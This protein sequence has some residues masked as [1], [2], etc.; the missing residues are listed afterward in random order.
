MNQYKVFAI[1]IFSLVCFSL[2]AADNPIA[3]EAERAHKMTY[4]TEVNPRIKTDSAVHKMRVLAS[5][6][7][8]NPIEH[9]PHDGVDLSGNTSLQTASC[10]LVNT[11]PTT[12]RSDF[13]VFDYGLYTLHHF[14][15]SKEGQRVAFNSMV[16]EIKNNA[17]YHFLI[18]KH[19]DPQ[20][21][22]ISI[23]T[24]LSLPTTGEFEILNSTLIE[25]IRIRVEAVMEDAN[26]NIPNPAE[27]ASV[28]KAGIDELKKVIESILNGTFNGELTEEVLGAG[29]FAEIVGVPSN[30]RKQ[31]KNTD[32]STMK[33]YTGLQVE[34]S[35]V[36]SYFRD[37]IAS[38]LTLPVISAFGLSYAFII[39]DDSNYISGEFE[40][41]QEFYNSSSSP[42]DLTLWFH[43]SEDE[44]MFLNIRNDIS[45]SK[46]ESITMAFFSDFLASRNGN[47]VAKM[48]ATCPPTI[49]D[50]L[51]NI[52]TWNAKDF[53]LPCI[54]CSECP[55]NTTA[56]ACYQSVVPDFLLGL[57]A[58]VFDYLI[59]IP[60]LVYLAGQGLFKATDYLNPTNPFFTN[61]WFGSV[62]T[63]SVRKSA[64][65]SGWKFWE[66]ELA[67]NTEE[68]MRRKLKTSQEF[69]ANISIDVPKML[70]GIDI[71]NSITSILDGIK[72]WFGNLTGSNGD[73]L[74]GY[75]V[76]RTIAEIVVAIFTAGT[77]TGSK[78][79]IG[80]AIKAIKDKGLK[81][82]LA[83]R[84]KE[85]DPIG[86]FKCK[87]LGLGCFV[88]GT[89]ILAAT[90]HVP[91]ESIQ[92]GDYVYANTWVNSQQTIMD[93]SGQEHPYD[94]F[95]SADQ[96]AV[97]QTSLYDTQW[98]EIHMEYPKADGSKIKVK[99]LRPQWWI[100]ER[101]VSKVGETLY[102]AL[103]E[104]GLQG[105][106][107]IVHLAHFRFTR[108][109]DDDDPDDDYE[110][111]PVTGTFELTSNDVWE[112][113]FENGEKL[114]V[115][116]IHPFYSLTL[117]N[118]Q[119]GSKIIIGENILSK[120][121]ENLSLESKRIIGSRKVFNLEIF[122]GH[123]FLVSNSG[124]VVHNS[125][126][127]FLDEA[128]K[129]RKNLGIKK[130]L[131]T[132]GYSKL[133]KD[134]PDSRAIK[135]HPK[136]KDKI[137][138][139]GNGRIK[140][141]YDDLGF[142]DFNDFVPKLPGIGPGKDGKMEWPIDMQ[143]TSN[144][145][146]KA[147]AKLNAALGKNFENNGDIFIDGY[148]NV[149][150]TF[151]HHQN[152]KTM[153]LV[154]KIINQGGADHLGGGKIAEKGGKGIFPG[155]EEIDKFKANCK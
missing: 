40:E 138:T 56:G 147:R 142:P 72:T 55:C 113:V 64:I 32:S 65:E 151:H 49:A 42:A 12:F 34:Q 137:E 67:K 100:D 20:S 95:T 76:G 79:I 88:A 39:T 94:P 71:F 146:N 129:I 26:N 115:T 53:I 109:Y 136:Y 44:K 21:L 13:Q 81:N 83:D 130:G 117:N 135:D 69:W 92:L 104:M 148:P 85:L 17:Q 27:F 57:A 66:W 52:G 51:A 1:S 5:V 4:R 35:G 14:T 108:N 74:Q 149:K 62:L 75:T 29:G 98:Y 61:I 84:W 18:A 15:N 122:K 125:C 152:G 45:E 19:I 123:N 10:D 8:C 128:D 118:W 127:T 143:G 91:I 126:K 111:R 2:F 16:E 155:P 63:A 3:L 121:N 119:N 47:L 89:P 78:L 60:S 37:N 70:E 106:A 22:K 73:K 140:I 153:Q 38:E 36:W 9:I 41:A 33:D 112:L 97:D 80:Q 24:A 46:G 77:V 145:M 101:K 120:D 59:E 99:L 54:G 134:T 48:T 96:R 144:D 50:F 133:I 23:K 103:P 114:E 7:T 30:T 102:I 110:L 90:G 6:A 43:F 116:G 28:E 87:I 124:I 132:P 11:F 150:W 82:F 68:E 25:S 131:G 139:D 105:F 154:P 58:G 93:E 31:D 86:K 107:D 141:C